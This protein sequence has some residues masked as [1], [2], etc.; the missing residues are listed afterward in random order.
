MLASEFGK[1]CSITKEISMSLWT[2]MKNWNIAVELI[3]N[4]FKSAYGTFREADER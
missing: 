2:A 4:F 3:V 1:F